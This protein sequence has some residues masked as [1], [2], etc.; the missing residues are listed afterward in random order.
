[1]VDQWKSVYL[2]VFV[3]LAVAADHCDLS[4]LKDHLDGKVL[5][6]SLRSPNINSRDG[7]SDKDDNF[8]CRSALSR[9]KSLYPLRVK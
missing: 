2:Q 9:R 4:P 7:V 5:T 3:W 1:M 8:S 6:V